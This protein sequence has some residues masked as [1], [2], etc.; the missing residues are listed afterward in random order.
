MTELEPSLLVS[1]RSIGDRGLS[2]LEAGLLFFPSSSKAL[3][4]ETAGLPEAATEAAIEAADEAADS[5]CWRR[6]KIWSIWGLGGFIIPVKGSLNSL[7][8]R[9]ELEVVLVVGLA[10][11]VDPPVE[12]GGTPPPAEAA[13]A[14]A[15]AMSGRNICM[16][17]K[18]FR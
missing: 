15:A 10:G 4:G 8:Q 5:S 9:L 11:L 13:A 1:S 7:L 14:A 3:C 6:P 16:Y 2:R 12:V 17:S 18:W